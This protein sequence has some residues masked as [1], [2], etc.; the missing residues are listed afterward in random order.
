VISLQIDLGSKKQVTGIVTQGAREF[1]H[2]QYIAAYKMAYSPD[3]VHWTEYKENGASESKVG[4]VCLS[5]LS[6][7]LPG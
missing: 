1:G 2:V 5:D 3:G 4:G 7:P 6:L